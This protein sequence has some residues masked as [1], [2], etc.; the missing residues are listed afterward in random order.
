MKDEGQSGP[1]RGLGLHPWLLEAG[2]PPSPGSVLPGWSVL[3]AWGPGT[4]QVISANSVA[5]EHPWATS[6]MGGSS[7]ASGWESIPGWQHVTCMIT[8]LCQGGGRGLSAV[9]TPPLG[10]EASQGSLL[11][12]APAASSLVM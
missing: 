5:R 2:G 4:T 11:D 12:P 3:L 10:E 7:S 8:C 6:H 1:Q 9:C